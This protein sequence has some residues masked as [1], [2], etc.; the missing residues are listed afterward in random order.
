MGS[1]GLKRLLLAALIA[2]LSLT[3]AIAIGIL[4]FGTFD[5]TT[6]RILGTTALIG[7]FSLVV[8]P[9]GILLDA[10]RATFLAW[11]VV[12]L[13]TAA[14]VGYVLLIWG[15]VDDSDPAWKTIG[16]IAVAA[17]AAS[18]TAATTGRRRASDP[19]AT[20][21]LYWLAIATAAV[22]TGFITAA[23]LT[24]AENEVLWRVLGAVAV[25]DVL[26]VLLQP[27]TRRYAAVPVPGQ[28]LPAQ[29]IRCTV[30]RLPDPMIH[31]DRYAAA[32][33]EPAAVEGRIPARDFAEAAATAIRELESAGVRV[34]S[35]ERGPAE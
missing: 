32:P 22:L 18:Q 3:A 11:S 35:V 23:I 2:S 8:L 7:A 15:L 6:A 31:P 9:A 28:P 14:F 21:W 26:V 19:W 17:G 12:V 24:E 5:D 29:R 13:A 27:A 10:G 16:I 30:D 4:L 33:G 34:L 25:L 1:L 20:V